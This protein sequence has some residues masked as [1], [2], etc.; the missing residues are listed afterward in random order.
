[1]LFRRQDIPK[2]TRTPK[3]GGTRRIYPRF[4]RDKRYLPKIDL[5]IDYLAGM[6]GQRRAELSQQTVAELLGEPKVAR[7]LLACLGDHF[8]YVTPS[9]EQIIGSSRA[10]DLLEWGLE[11]PSDLRAFVYRLA[12]D[13][14]GGF[15]TSPQ[16][17]AFLAELARPLGLDADILSELLHLDAERN[18]ILQLRGEKPNSVDVVASYNA[19]M[20]P[21]TLRQASRAR[22]NLEGLSPAQVE[23]ICDHHDVAW[24]IDEQSVV[25]LNGIRDSHGSYSRHG[26]KLA[27]CIHQLVLLA[28]SVGPID[29]TVYL[30]DRLLHLE[31]DERS[32]NYLR[33]RHVYVA[34]GPAIEAGATIV[35]QL[36]THRAETGIGREWIF[37]RLPDCRVINGALVLP[38]IT[39]V[40]EHCAIDLVF[41]DGSDFNERERGALQQIAERYPMLVMN[42]QIENVTTVTTYDPAEVFAML[43]KMYA[44]QTSTPELATLIDGL[45][46]TRPFI[47]ASELLSLCGSNSRHHLALHDTDSVVFVPDLGL[48]ERSRLRNL[49]TMVGGATPQIAAVRAAAADQF[50]EEVADALTIRLL[51]H[52]QI[53]LAAA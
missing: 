50:G 44:E 30:N 45:I 42:S 6:V 51:S 37:R 7:C 34:D 5:A 21:S 46:R 10:T 48:F 18:A 39:A 32:L 36:I 20:I 19:R 52:Y 12:N 16:R 47:P 25:E 27:R 9:F 24:R 8:H 14:Q 4:I 11:T 41:A 35:D 17:D 15:V 2:T 13:R 22:L 33:P 38:E 53:V 29:A 40:R 26:R 3:G 1:M 43:D 31:L 49:E 28:D 23:S